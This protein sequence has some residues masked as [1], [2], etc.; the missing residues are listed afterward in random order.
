MAE[1]R[2]IIDNVPCF[3]FKSIQI[4]R[5][6]ENF[7]G[8][9]SFTATAA[10]QQAFPIRRGAYAVVTI[11]GEPV[12]T[13]WVETISP[14]ISATDHMVNIG[15]RDVTC[16]LVDSTLAA[17]SVELTTPVTL[18]SIIQQVL[19][20]LGLELEIVNN[21]PSLEPYGADDLVACE[22]GQGAFDFIEQHARKKQVLITTD[23]RGRIV[24]AR[25]ETTQA[26]FRLTN[27]IGNSSN[28][29]LDSSAV[30]DDSQRFNRYIVQSQGNMVGANS[31]GESD[32]D[33]IVNVTSQAAIDNQ[34]RR[35]RVLHLVAENSALSGTAF[36]R[37]TW[38]ASVRKA[39]SM[40][41][42]AN[43]DGI[44]DYD[45]MPHAF[46]R[47]IMVED[48]ACDISARMLIKSVA[49]SISDGGADTSF[50]L[51]TEGSYTLELEQP[52]P[53]KRT[54]KI[55]DEFN[56]DEDESE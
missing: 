32:F 7:C 2:L 36:D 3:N 47:L 21:V 31:F 16:D 18:V 22:A 37:A 41:Y 55:G 15:G 46:N 9:F 24:I 50:E 34:V 54:N 5:S 53:R 38:E 42:S 51:A 27:M 44:T 49:F 8:T 1:V 25:A 17:D 26:A 20:A 4:S 13:G 40:T 52:A 10:D 6:I 45:D 43:V 11:N 29:V 39:R 28:N 33:D 30:Y 35:G 23:G 56:E 12:V 48:F 19:D 14:S